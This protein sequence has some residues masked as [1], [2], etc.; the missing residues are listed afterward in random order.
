M[1]VVENR[2]TGRLL[3]GRQNKERGVMTFRTEA[4]AVAYLERKRLKTHDWIVRVA[5]AK[6]RS[7]YGSPTYP[8]VRHR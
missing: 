6:E 8:S 1:L 5:D 7:E 2:L 4:A 3:M